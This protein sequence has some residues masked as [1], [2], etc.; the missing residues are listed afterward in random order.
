MK[1]PRAILPLF[2][3]RL[4]PNKVVLLI[5]PRRVGKTVFIKN[6][7]NGLSIDKCLILNGDDVLDMALLKERSVPN[8]KRLLEGKEYLII[9]EAQHIPD[10]GMILKLIVDSIDGIKVIASGSSAFDLYHQVGEPLVGRKS[11][12]YLYPLAQMEISK[13]EDFRTTFINR[14]ERLIFGSYPELDQYP[15]WKDKEGYLKEVMNDYLLKDILIYDGLKNSD[16]LFSLLKLIAFQVGKEVSLDELGR[17]LGMSKNTVERYLDLLAKVFVVYK[18]SGFSKNLRK[19]VS[20]SSRWYFYDNGVRNAIIQNFNRLDMRMDVGELWENYLAS[21]RLKYQSYHQIN[22][23]NYFWRTYDQQEID[24]VEEEGDQ[25]RGFEFKYQLNKSI[26][27]PAAWSKAYP[28]ASFEVIHQD[29]YL[30]WIV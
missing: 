13:L 4:R 23:N 18:V 11:T 5:G 14:E 24:W 16:K 2:Q 10:I 26:K 1:Y 12:L 7:V 30:D 17:Q 19:E 28:E 6:F 9:D 29:N 21:E 8:Y 15:N 20:K 25:L 22:C 27:P 3:K